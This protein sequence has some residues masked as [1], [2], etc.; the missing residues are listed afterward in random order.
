MRILGLGG[1]CNLGENPRLRTRMGSGPSLVLNMERC[2]RSGVSGISP[3]R[4]NEMTSGKS[5]T[6]GI[7]TMNARNRYST[8]R[9]GEPPTVL[10]VDHDPMARSFEVKL[11][12][13]QGYNVLQAE[14]GEE[15]LRLA[16]KATIHLLLTDFWMPDVDG[17]E[18]T[19]KFRTV[20]PETPVLMVSSSLPP[21]DNGIEDLARFG[22]LPKPFAFDELLRTVRTLIQA[23]APFPR[24]EA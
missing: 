20:H 5:L 15:A 12:S 14:S 8:E 24:R 10:V 1:T 21:T 3:I 11:L 17:L 18:L 7:Q 6:Q 16:D 23:K 13:S 2:L 4:H 9:I 19:R 22:F